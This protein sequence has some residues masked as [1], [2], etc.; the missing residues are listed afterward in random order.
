MKKVFLCLILVVLALFLCSCEQPD[1]NN[2]VQS[3]SLNDV[4]ESLG[5]INQIYESSNTRFVTGET[6]L[7]YYEG[8]DVVFIGKLVEYNTLTKSFADYV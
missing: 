1:L 4:I 5:S 8:T 2:N 3:N 6:L 7:N